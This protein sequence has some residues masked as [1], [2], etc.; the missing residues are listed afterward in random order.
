MISPLEALA[1]LTDADRADI[2]R[3]MSGEADEDRIRRGDVHDIIR[4]L[5]TD[6]VPSK[7]YQAALREV[8]RLVSKLVQSEP[9]AAKAVTPG[10]GKGQGS[11]L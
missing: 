4:S 6:P 9:I 11:R 5:R 8:Q 7:E 3:I 10:S 1:N 2:R